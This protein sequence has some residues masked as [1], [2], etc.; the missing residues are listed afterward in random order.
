VDRQA[1]GEGASFGNAGLIQREAVFPHPFPR[2]LA[3]LS[4]IGRNRSIDASYH[5]GAM[6]QLASPLLQYWWNSHPDRYALAVKG[7]AQLIATCIDEHM[8]VATEAKATDLLRPIGYHRMFGNAAKLAAAAA[9]AE[10]AHREY[11]VNYALLDGAALAAAEPS[12]QVEKI[13]AIH[14][15]D[16]LSCS[17]PNGLVNA[18][19]RLFLE[20][21][22]KL[23]LG[24]A[25][26]LHRVGHGWQ[27]MTQDGPVEAASAVIA[28]GAASTQ[29]TAPLG[30]KPPLFGKR[31]YHMHYNLRGNAVLNRPLLDGD[32]GFM[33]IPMRYG[34][35]LTT[36]AEFAK[37]GADPTPV[38]LQ[39][40][41]PVARSLIP[42]ADRVDEAPWMG[43]R[44][45]TPDMVPIIGKAPRQDNL[46]LCF[47]HAHQGLTLG[48][49]SG[50]LIAEMMTG[51]APFVDP[52]PYAP[53]RFAA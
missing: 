43:V 23:A 19:A 34:I 21:G 12:L 32:S 17:D 42:L 33:L 18:Y 45:T 6:P 7:H 8:A 3:E 4:R 48:P 46:W 49:S 31:G 30:Y 44:P 20:L 22:G 24:D 26:T 13:G 14:W 1:P 36:G 37:T 28:L 39:R 40:A 53:E 51:D 2:S 16:P 5:L 38:Q 52:A 25:T 9:E 10:R 47:G 11:G 50:R 27:V 15:T 29:V 41:E 35:R